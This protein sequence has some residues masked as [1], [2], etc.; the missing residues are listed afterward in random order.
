MKIERI[1]IKFTIR[2]IVMLL[3][4]AILLTACGGKS[5]KSDTVHESVD[6]TFA[7]DTKQ[8]L[9]ELD[10]IAE[11]EEEPSEKAIEITERYLDLYEGTEK[12]EVEAEIYSS[13]RVLIGSIDIKRYLE[14]DKE[15]YR[16]IQDTILR[17]IETGSYVGK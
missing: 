11:T 16:N 1:G 14:S 5:G 2:N 13:T 10:H 8:V 6:K 15:N 7:A 4:V 9:K 3:I 12:N 17:L